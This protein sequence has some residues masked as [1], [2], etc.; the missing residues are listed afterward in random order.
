MIL[1]TRTQKCVY[2][3][4]QDVWIEMVCFT[5]MQ[6]FGGEAAQAAF[7]FCPEFAIKML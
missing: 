5:N 3:T 1:S 7:F 2:V 6:T 4:S